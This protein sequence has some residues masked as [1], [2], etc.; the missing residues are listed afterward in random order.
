MLMIEQLKSKI[1]GL[2]EIKKY[3]A[4]GQKQ[5]YLV[6]TDEHDAVILKIIENMDDR[7]QREIDIVTKND[8]TDVPKIIMFDYIEYDNNKHFYI[9]EEFIDGK[10]IKEVL[11]DGAMNLSD[12]INLLEGLLTTVSELESIQIVHR[13]IKPENIIWGKDGKFHLIDFGIARNLNL[14]S[15]TLSK[16]AVGP[17]TPGYGAPELFQ[18]DKPNIN[19]KADLF[20]IG[21][22]VYE[23]I[24][25]KHP[26]LTGR[27][28]D[29][30][31][32]WYKTATATPMN[33]FIDG[34]NDRQLIGFIQTLMQKH[35]SKR[36]PNAKKALEWFFI[37]KD[38]LVL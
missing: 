9:L 3:P 12:S 29:L 1:K 15:L 14:P 11:C 10:S 7:I 16:M 17:H 8:I 20:S 21:V 36:P 24:F 37:V 27:E 32:I 26:F 2:K 38:T 33:L 30:N 28:L 23:A 13:D 34:D 18:Y 6:S 31:E 19:S 22:V 35:V 5:V 25:G 4:S